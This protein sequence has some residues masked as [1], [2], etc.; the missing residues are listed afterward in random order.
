MTCVKRPKCY[1]ISQIS[2]DLGEKFWVFPLA[3]GSSMNFVRTKQHVLLSEI[4]VNSEF[5]CEM[6]SERNDKT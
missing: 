6:L 2:L 1:D 3:R 4:L 5:Y